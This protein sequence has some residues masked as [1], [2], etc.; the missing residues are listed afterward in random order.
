MF[1]SKISRSFLR[2]SPLSPTPSPLAVGGS[3]VHKRWIIEDVL[4]REGVC[5][6][7]YSDRRVA[8]W[9]L[10]SVS[11]LGVLPIERASDAGANQKITQVNEGKSDVHMIAHNTPRRLLSYVDHSRLRSV[12]PPPSCS[13]SI[14]PETFSALKSP[15]NGR[16]RPPRPPA[17]PP[18]PPPSPA[19]PRLPMWWTRRHR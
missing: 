16:G 14:V 18:P 9:L 15:A 11:L 3:V 10:D 13:S 2:L 12:F 8:R 19:C 4:Q 7:M 5:Q 1:T 6:C 17:R